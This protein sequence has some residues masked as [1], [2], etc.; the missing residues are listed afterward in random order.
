MELC[1]W[2]VLVCKP[3]DADLT[4]HHTNCRWANQV[5]AIWS[6]IRNTAPFSISISTRVISVIWF[7]KPMSIWLQP[8][9]CIENTLVLFQYAW[10][11]LCQNKNATDMKNGYT[12]TL[13]SNHQIKGVWFIKTT[14]LHSKTVRFIFFFLL[15]E[16]FYSNKLKSTRLHDVHRILRNQKSRSI[17]NVQFFSINDRA[18]S[19]FMA[20]SVFI[21]IKRG[22]HQLDFR[23]QDFLHQHCH[24]LSHLNHYHYHCHPIG[25]NHK[26]S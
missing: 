4:L 12:C 13:H 25:C 2:Y 6:H 24:Y 19:V 5:N 3:N 7:V 21:V 17:F 9:G 11:F 1:V 18:G 16:E 22:F 20:M 10:A 15:L 23:P 8:Y 14:L 26:Y